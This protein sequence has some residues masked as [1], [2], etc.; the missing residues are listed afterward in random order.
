MDP[1]QVCCM[2]GRYSLDCL[3]LLLNHYDVD[4]SDCFASFLDGILCLCIELS[5][6]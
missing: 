2:E 6:M 1:V 4:T 3:P 5:L